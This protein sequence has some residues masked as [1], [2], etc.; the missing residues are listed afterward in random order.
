MIEESFTRLRDYC[1][2][3]NYKGWDPY[4]GLNSAIFQATPFKRWDIAR[5]VL[6]QLCKRS[7]VNLRPL[8]LVPKQ[9]NAKGVG[10]FLNGYCNLYRLAE[11]GD[12]RFGSL[13]EL[14]SKIDEVGGLLMTLQSPGYSG[15]CWGYNF[16]WQARRLFLFPAHTPTVVATTFCA[17]ALFEAYE[18]TGNNLYLS[19]ALSSADFVLKDLHRSEHKG[20]F[21]LSY[22]PLPGNDT[23]Y[24]ASL[25]GAKLLSYCYHYTGN[26]E[27][28]TVARQIV[29]AACEGQAKDGSWVY[30]LLPVQSWIDS[31]HTGYNLDAISHYT[32]LCGD[33]AYKVHL[34]KGLKFYLENFFLP[35]G[36]PKYYHNKTYPIDIHCPGQL[37]VTL[38]QMDCWQGNAALCES[39]A[40]WT[41]AN[42]QSPKGYFY[43]QLKKGVSSK[44]PYMRWSNAFMFNAL[45]YYLLEQHGQ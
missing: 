14:R 40:Q 32:R 30:G 19:T 24:N 16:D 7:P 9:H 25:L 44:I 33:N 41:V 17:S 38:S 36:T 1:E 20:G 22:S 42:M 13:E 12:T 6:I 29:N 3:E 8:L 34:D 45:S 2:A 35:D 23:V 15:A 28:K 11:Q 21:M 43:Y 5:L 26:E 31:F 4:D 37:W 39:V 18:I 27:Y 10:L